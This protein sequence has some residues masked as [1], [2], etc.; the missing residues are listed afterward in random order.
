MA[1]RGISTS[2]DLL[3]AQLAV[4][5]RRLADVP[6]LKS[7]E[8]WPAVKAATAGIVEE[9]LR[10][11]GARYRETCG[12]YVLRMGGFAASSTMSQLGA[13]K[14]WCANARRRLGKDGAQ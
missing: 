1:Q 12:E 10:E 3:E 8:D 6:E 11:H 7:Y 5:E 14:N 9:L 13:L 4:V 2:N